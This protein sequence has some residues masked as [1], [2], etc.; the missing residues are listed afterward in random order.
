[1]TRASPV[2]QHEVLYARRPV[3]GGPNNAQDSFGYRADGL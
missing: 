3:G 1:M 2:K